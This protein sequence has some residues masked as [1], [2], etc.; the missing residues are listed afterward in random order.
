MAVLDVE[1]ISPF[2]TECG[3]AFL[4]NF[5]S[6]YQC[7]EKQASS[8]AFF[9]LT[10]LPWTEAMQCG[11]GSFFQVTPVFSVQNCCPQTPVTAEIIIRDKTVLMP[12]LELTSLREIY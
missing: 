2:M 6:P 4:F 8:T 9:I 7:P 3:P 10:H 12:K 1:M 11:G 5:C